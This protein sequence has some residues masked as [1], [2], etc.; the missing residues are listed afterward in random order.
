MQDPEQ[1]G[2][3]ATPYLRLMALTVIGYLWS[4]MAGT[5][6]KQLDAEEGHRPLLE[7]KLVSAQYYYDRILPEVEWLLIDIKSGKDS[8][9]ALEDAHWAA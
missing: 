7:S 3:A 8:M 4:R 5:A 2:A 6:Q 1:A 9:M